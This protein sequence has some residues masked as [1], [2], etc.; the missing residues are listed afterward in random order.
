MSYVFISTQLSH[1]KKKSHINLEEETILILLLNYTSTCSWSVWALG[2]ACLRPW[3]QTSPCC[4]LSGNL[5]PLLGKHLTEVP[6]SFS[7]V[8]AEQGLK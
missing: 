8:R 3:D 2:D 4:L 1:L 6:L 7:H 5:V